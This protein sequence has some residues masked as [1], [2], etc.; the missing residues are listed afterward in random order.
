MIQTIELTEK[1]KLTAYMK[2]SKKE[3][4]KM[5]IENQKWLNV[6]LAPRLEYDSPKKEI[7]II[8][9]SWG[10]INEYVNKENK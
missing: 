4:A 10:A 7:E 2:M 1:E 5:L 9:L 3:L 6:L 8:D